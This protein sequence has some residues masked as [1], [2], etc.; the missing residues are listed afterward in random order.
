MLAS[1]PLHRVYQLKSG[2]LASG[3]N[4][5]S[6]AKVGKMIGERGK[7]AGIATVVFDRGGFIYSA[8]VK[9]LADAAREAGLKF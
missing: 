9:A 2:G 1:L 7:S 5:E 4:A 8:K 3:S 6:A